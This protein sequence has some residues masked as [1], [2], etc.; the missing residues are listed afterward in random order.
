MNSVEELAEQFW[1]K[2]YVIL[3]GYFKAGL[4]DQYNDLILEHFGVNPNWEHT[5]EF[6]SKSATEVIPWF[7][8]MEGITNFNTVN[9]DSFLNELTE[10]VIGEDWANL[11]CMC[12]FSK[13]G[14]KGQAWHQ[15]C[16]PEDPNI[17]NLNRLIYT[18]DI[19]PEIGGELCIME[20][21][22]KVGLLPA[23]LPDE[24]FEEQLEFLPKKGTVVLLH[25]HCWHKVKPIKGTSRVSTNFRAVPK[26]VPNDVTDV[27]VY[28]NMR[29]RFST[30]EVIEE[31]IY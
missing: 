10:R 29:Y 9:E 3:D 23:G 31:R 5:N 18:H 4:M 19:T 14:S 1:E 7:P 15:D 12:M 21:T 22:H 28:R 2:G 26:G 16:A 20:E 24:D 17:F 8:Q 6:V 27:C 13:K 25:G 11:Y 30:N